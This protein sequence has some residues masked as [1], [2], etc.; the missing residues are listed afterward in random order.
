MGYGKRDWKM[1][2][3]ERSMTK[4]EINKLSDILWDGGIIEDEI[5]HAFPKVKERYNQLRKQWKEEESKYQQRLYDYERIGKKYGGRI[6]GG[7]G[8]MKF[9]VGSDGYEKANMEWRKLYGEDYPKLI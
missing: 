6:F 2:K 4:Q 8:A 9:A 5:L 3:Y 7:I 1:G